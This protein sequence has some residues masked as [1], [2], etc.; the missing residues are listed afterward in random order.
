MTLEKGLGVGPGRVEMG[1]VGLDH[2]V[3]GPDTIHL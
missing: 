3:F 2:E 1:V